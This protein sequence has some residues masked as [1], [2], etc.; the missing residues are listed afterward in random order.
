MGSRNNPVLPLDAIKPV[1]LKENSFVELF[2][3]QF[4]VLGYFPHFTCNCIED[5]L[6]TTLNH[7]RFWKA[8]SGNTLYMAWDGRGLDW[9][10]E[11][12]VGEAASHHSE[13]PQWEEL[14]QALL[15]TSRQAKTRS[16]N[17]RLKIW[18]KVQ[19]QKP[20][21]TAKLCT[22]IIH[23]HLTRGQKVNFKIFIPSVTIKLKSLTAG[24]F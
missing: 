7:F 20:A 3:G 17:Q 16:V 15:L 4:S 8:N 5:I 18:P 10:R 19:R 24:C 21:N 14:S 22:A 12:T 9:G 1:F 2:Q 11:S 6:Y 23:S 13:F